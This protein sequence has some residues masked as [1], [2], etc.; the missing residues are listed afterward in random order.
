M[1]CTLLF[2]GIYG[3]YKPLQ[4]RSE[5]QITKNF[6]SYL[7]GALARNTLPEKRYQV[8]FYREDFV[9]T[10]LDTPNSPAGNNF[11]TSL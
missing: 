3:T 10:S 9:D 8:V 5:L 2:F 1:I 4:E 7:S 6:D 11:D